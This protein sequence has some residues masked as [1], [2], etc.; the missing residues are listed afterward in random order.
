MKENFFITGYPRSRTA[1]LSVLLTTKN[2]FCYHEVL[3]FSETISNVKNLMSERDEF[4]VG[5]SGSDCLLFM[6]DII[7]EKENTPIVVIE[8]NIKSVNK[9]LRGIFDEY[10]TEVLE[11]I[12]DGLEVVKTIPGAISVNYKDLDKQKTI[13][14]IWEHCLPSIPFDKERWQIL[15]TLNISIDKKRYMKSL[16]KKTI[17][18]INNS[19]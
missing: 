1:W 5:S 11:S 3:R 9:S 16:T 12:R 7:F 15:K 4:Y 8:R 13:K 18:T 19:L 14:R 17:Q 10:D 2:S 6:E